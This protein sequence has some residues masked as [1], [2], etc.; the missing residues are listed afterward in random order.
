MTKNKYIIAIIFLLVS[1]IG[2]KP[3][4]PNLVLTSL[5]VSKIRESL[6]KV[7]LF[8]KSFEDAKVEIDKAID[9]P[10]DVP[11]PKDAGGGYTHEKHKQNYNEMYLAGFLYQITG[12]KKYAI[13]I[14][15]VL[16]QYATLYP[17][18]GKHPQGKKQT[19]GRMF[20]QSL[21]ETVWLLHTIQA[22]DAIFDWLS[23]SDRENYEDNIFNPMVKFF[24]TECKHEFDLIHNHGTWIVAAVGMTGYVLG[25]DEYVQQALYGSEKDGKTGYIAQLDNLF[26][27]D[28]Y[29]TEGGYYVR[30]ALWPFFIFAEAINNNQPELKI[31]EHRSQI[32]KKAL[33]SALQVTDTHGAFIP[34][35]DAII[36]KNWLSPELIFA[37]NFVYAHYEHDRQLLYLVN[38]HDRV[39]LS[40]P[41]LMAAKDVMK[42]EAIP[43][44]NWE[45]IEY[46][47]GPDGS[48]GGVGI[49]RNGDASDQETLFMKYGSHGLS[50]G[51]YD[52]LTFLFYDNG[53]EII[54]DY[55]SARFINVEQK[56]GGRYLDENDSFA[57]Q[58]VA[59]NTVVVDEKTQYDG[60]QKA[61]QKHHSERYCF[62]A[63]DKN[64]Q[65]VSAKENKA[66][67][68]VNMQR[69]MVM[70]NDEKFIKP[71]IIDVFKVKSES[72]HIYDLPF[73]Y[74]GHFVAANFEY[75]PAT[76]TK[77]LMGEAN[78]YQHLWKDAYATVKSTSQFTW[79]QGTRF[80]T[81]TTN[82]DDGDNIY[83]TQIGGTDP[84]FNLRN[85]HG[86][87]IRK[88]GKQKTFASII[89]PHGEF[90]P[91]MEFT[92]DSYPSIENISVIYDEDDYTIVKISG[93]NKIDWTLMLANNNSD[94][95]SIHEINVANEKYKWT[96]PVQIIKQ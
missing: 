58:T 84:N 50:H 70:V 30:Y 52:K 16:D 59:H 21:N 20:W 83:F 80:Y 51:H 47:D 95:K 34:I 60:I 32:L 6:G 19:P 46:T 96:G 3:L 93:K 55:G 17:K 89:E 49:L 85:E 56:F 22:Y 31:Y 41:G 76:S 38:L 12:D 43:V 28:G 71:I 8:D 92:K 27:P 10:M 24:M 48:W 78:G 94:K 1:F 67:S 11:F 61:S 4:H 53:K 5:D 81:V 33:Y 39:S 75:T 65:Y 23:Q 15:T 88:N 73:Y 7:P 45:S 37:S 79:L 74:L 68:G 57:K 66:Y 36:E 64:F 90:N 69:T 91:V 54:Q 40:G 35:N 77:S 13:F 42:P 87:I 82:T 26:S 18:L 25:N 14:K 62:N 9:S 29:Y 63:D 86:F 2:G 44:F 72:E